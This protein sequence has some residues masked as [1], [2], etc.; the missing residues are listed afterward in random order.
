MNIEIT[1]KLIK[2]TSTLKSFKLF[3]KS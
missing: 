2:I 1:M 3:K